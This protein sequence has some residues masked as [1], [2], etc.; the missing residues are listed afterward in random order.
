[1][2]VKTVFVKKDITLRMVF[3]FNVLPGAS[4][5][6]NC[7]IQA[8]NLMVNQWWAEFKIFGAYAWFFILVRGMKF[9]YYNLLQTPSETIHV[10]CPLYFLKINNSFS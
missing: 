2:A 10:A 1:M 6:G 3:A 5:Q 4:A 8:T 7:S 9:Q